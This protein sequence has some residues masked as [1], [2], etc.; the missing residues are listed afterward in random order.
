MEILS[1]NYERKI[2]GERIVHPNVINFLSINSRN[3]NLKIKLKCK[4]KKK[5]K[6]YFEYRIH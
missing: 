3:E 6:F 1:L 4:M 5:K 2:Y